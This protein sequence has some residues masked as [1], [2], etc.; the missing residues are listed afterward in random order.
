MARENY[1]AKDHW[2]CLAA[3]FLIGLSPFQYGV[4]FGLIGGFQ[5]SKRLPS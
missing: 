2:R 3:C 5:V 4:D 1:K